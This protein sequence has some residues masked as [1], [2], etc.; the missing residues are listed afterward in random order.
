MILRNLRTEAESLAIVS[1]IVVS[2]LA[3]CVIFS[4][5]QGLG[6]AAAFTGSA[7]TKASLPRPTAGARR[8]Q[9][10]E[11]AVPAHKPASAS[12]G[13]RPRANLM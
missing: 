6:P 7:P 1:I 10:P 8:E 5:Y 11:A 12:R 3:W 4:P 2:T 13:L 9:S